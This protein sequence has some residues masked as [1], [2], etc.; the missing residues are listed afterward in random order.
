MRALSLSPA[1]LDW[2]CSLLPCRCC[3]ARGPNRYHD[4]G[5]HG[6]DALCLVCEVAEAEFLQQSPKR[7]ADMLH[8]SS[9]AQVHA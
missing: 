4:A 7:P 3:G 2:L 6:V 9:S 5:E 1:A 8:C